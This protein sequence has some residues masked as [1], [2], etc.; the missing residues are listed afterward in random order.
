MLVC[1]PKL[2]KALNCL[3]QGSSIG[4][5]V[6]CACLGLFP[7]IVSTSLSSI[8]H[9]TL[10]NS[11]KSAESA[12]FVLFFIVRTR[13][14]VLLSELG[15]WLVIVV[16]LFRD[17]LIVCQIYLK[18]VVLFIG[19]SLKISLFSISTEFPQTSIL[20]RIFL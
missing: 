14:N 11:G 20:P 19:R 8:F 17:Y 1:Q 6:L 13:A 7:L 12:D 15:Y 2:P 3:I 16:M 9:A 10:S 5:Q 18:I 4:P